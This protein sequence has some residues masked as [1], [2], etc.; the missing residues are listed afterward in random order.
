MCFLILLYILCGTGL[1]CG[2]W[3]VRAYGV[4]GMWCV[5]HGE[6]RDM[7]FAGIGLFRACGVLSYCMFQKSCEINPAHIVF[8]INL[9]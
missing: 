8:Y 3:R 9:S 2:A 5:G 7:L 6:V 1:L 4:R